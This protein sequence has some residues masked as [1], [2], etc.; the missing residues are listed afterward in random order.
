[1]VVECL[2]ERAHRGEL[3]V[4]LNGSFKH[5]FDDS[6]DGAAGGFQLLANVPVC[7]VAGRAIAKDVVLALDPYALD[8]VA[9][10]LEVYSPSKQLLIDP[11]VGEQRSS[12]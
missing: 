12:E 2:D 11:S 10:F 4:K 3:G 7:R 9:H 1:M 6:A 5:S 8:L